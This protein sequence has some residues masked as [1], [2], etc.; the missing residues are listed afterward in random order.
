MPVKVGDG[1]A[2]V[3]VGDVGHAEDA[4]QIQQNVVRIDGQRSVYVPVL[5]QG[6]ANTIAVVDGVRDAPAEDL[7]AART[8]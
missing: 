7:R 6:S 8:A 4:A 5:K 1:E 3:L 2:P